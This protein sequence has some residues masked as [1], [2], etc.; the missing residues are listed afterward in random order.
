MKTVISFIMVLMALVIM[1]PSVHAVTSTVSVQLPTWP[2]L[3]LHVYVSPSCSHWV[4]QIDDGFK[5]WQTGFQFSYDYT[6][7]T[8]RSPQTIYVFCGADAPSWDTSFGHDCAVYSMPCIGLTSIDVRADNHT[9]SVTIWLQD[10]VFL[11][12]IVVH[13]LGHSFGLGHASTDTCDVMYFELTLCTNPH[14]SPADFNALAQAYGIIPLPETQT[15]ILALILIL[16]TATIMMRK[17]R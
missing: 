15:P 16:V 14:P 2:S 3:D 4:S 8:T 7:N 11:P 17:K 13:E 1:V 10:G 5:Q 12:L 9:N 6:S